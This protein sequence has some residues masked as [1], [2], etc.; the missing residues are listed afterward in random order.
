MAYNGGYQEQGR[1]YAGPAVGRP[2]P[3]RPQYPAGPNGSSGPGP[4]QYN[5]APPHPQ[6]YD[7]YQ[8]DDYGYGYNDGYGAGYDQECDQGYSQQYDDV[9]YGRGPPPH[10]NYPPLQ[11]NYYGPAPRR[12]GP[13]MGRGRGPPMGRPPPPGDGRGQYPPRSG[14]PGPGPGR[15]GYPPQARGGRPTNQRHGASDPTGLCTTNSS[16][17]R[18]ETNLSRRRAKTADGSSDLWRQRFRWRRI[19]DFPGQTTKDRLGRGT[20]NYRTDGRGGYIRFTKAYNEGPWWHG[21]AASTWAPKFRRRIWWPI[22]H[23]WLWER[24]TSALSSTA[25]FAGVKTGTTTKSRLWCA[26]HRGI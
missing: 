25:R 24:T 11:Q 9:N 2:A 23:G 12:G 4:Q 17:E 21:A 26:T 6:Q 22:P 19:S 20:A 13:P 8:Q 3:P 10:Q 16:K 14:G 18:L 1:P 5:D 7:Q 15:G